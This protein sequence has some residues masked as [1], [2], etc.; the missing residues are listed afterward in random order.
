M[1]DTQHTPAEPVSDRDLSGQRL[2][3]YQLLRRLGRGGMADVYLAQQ[4]SL[5][6]QVA[7]KVLKSHLAC[8]ESYVRRFENEARS[9]AA[10]VHGNIVQ[11]HE[12]SCI[13]GLHFIAQEYVPGRNLRQ[14]VD[15][16]GAV[17]AA[18]AVNVMRQ[19]ASALHKAGER[20]IIH[21]D[22]KP[23]NIMLSASGEVKV[24]DFGLARTV[25]GDVNLTQVGITMGTPLY[26]SPE[27]AEGKPV[28]QRSDLYSLGV[29]SYFMLT[30]R[31]PFDAQTPLGLAVKHLKEDPKRLEDARPDLPNGLCCIVHK[32]M[33]KHPGD[34]FQNAMELLRELR[35]L[36]IDGLEDGWPSA[37]ELFN[38]AELATLAG[39]RL[40][41][42]QR[43]DTV[44][45]TEARLKPRTSRRWL[46]FASAVAIGLLAGILLAWATRPGPLLAPSKATSAVPRKESPLEQYRYATWAQT[47]EAYQSVAEYFPVE[48]D[49]P[50]TEKAQRQLNIRRANQRL[51]ELYVKNHDYELAM[52]LF[53]EFA[54]MEETALAFRAFGIAGQA[55]VYWHRGDLDSMND[56]LKEV[57]EHRS[58]L[59]RNMLSIVD[60]LNET[61]GRPTGSARPREPGVDRPAPP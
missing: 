5:R 26:M 45:K 11:I 48:P 23:E 6:R 12:V 54:N 14:F 59:N 47:E 16:Q 28:D 50:A 35:T 49:L 36:P 2:G 37:I 29:T 46:R 22:I 44:M 55:L 53:T 57:Y 32:M 18:M 42:T 58:L 4:Q 15:S 40:A 24:A 30:G 3:D 56:K 1:A 7:F 34:R 52:P 41:A 20:N 25:D 21:R 9:A 27:Q 38:N 39:D 19:V 8:D 61:R 43:L 51:A 10:L 17:D 60:R 31:P 33:A 13:N